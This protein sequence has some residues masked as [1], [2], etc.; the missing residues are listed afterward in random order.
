MQQKLNA[1]NL[2]GMTRLKDRGEMLK[3][4]VSPYFK[5]LSFSSPSYFILNKGNGSSDIT[6][7]LQMYTWRIL[8]KD[9]ALGKEHLVS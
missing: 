3:V 7:K 9:R 5:H 6:G 2:M 4:W 1:Q 8:H